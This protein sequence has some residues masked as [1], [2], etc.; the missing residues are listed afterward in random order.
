MRIGERAAWITCLNKLFT[1]KARYDCAMV[2]LYNYFV[3]CHLVIE[4]PYLS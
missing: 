3:S 1:I 2:A 4:S